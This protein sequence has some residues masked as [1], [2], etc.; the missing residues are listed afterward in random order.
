[1]SLC[2]RCG[3]PLPSYRFGYG[4]PV[5]Y[6]GDDCRRGPRESGSVLGALAVLRMG[7]GLEWQDRAACKGEDPDLFFPTR[8]RG[9]A[10]AGKAIC[11][12]CPVR[13][14]CLEF[15][16]NTPGWDDCGIWGG[17]SAGER[18]PIR[19][20]RRRREREAA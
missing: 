16:V 9:K 5:E 8:G 19:A 1:M 2:A 6:C 11:A 4:R 3:D 12:V 18:R 20:A 13:R 10:K 7:E 17:T 14:E 15:A